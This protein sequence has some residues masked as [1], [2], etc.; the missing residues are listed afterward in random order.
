M[1]DDV[2]C[3]R[4]SYL[5]E[6][7]EDGWRGTINQI[8]Y[9]LIGHG[10]LSDPAPAQVARAMVER[11]Y[12]EAGPEDYSKGI[13]EALAHV[14]PIAGGIPISHSEQAIRDFLARVAV[15]LT[16]LQP[17]PPAPGPR[18]RPRLFGRLVA[19]ESGWRPTR[20]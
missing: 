15:E 7:G 2:Q 3:Y 12:F 8:L 6:P 10:D 13:S 1:P 19:D 4:A 17:W 11:R 16:S 5:S 20:P 14:G 18:S 9:T